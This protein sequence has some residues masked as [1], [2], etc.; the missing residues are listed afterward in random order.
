M[1][2]PLY[3]GLLLRASLAKR[4]SMSK[5]PESRACKQ[6]LILQDE[7]MHDARLQY[8]A[9]LCHLGGPDPFTD[10]FFTLAITRMVA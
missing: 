1:F 8:V 7:N 10:T 5:G 9:L 4:L 3:T 2:K 6:T